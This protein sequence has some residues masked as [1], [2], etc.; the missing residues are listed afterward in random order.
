MKTNTIGIV[1]VWKEMQ[2]AQ[3]ILTKSVNIFMSE[4][5]TDQVGKIFRRMSRCAVVKGRMEG[6]DGAH[7][8]K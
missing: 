7:G 8:P 4:R 5:I 1:C 2:A 6:V 3:A